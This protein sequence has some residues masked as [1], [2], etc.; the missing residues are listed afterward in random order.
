MDKQGIFR[1]EGNV[2]SMQDLRDSFDSG[3]YIDY[4]KFEDVNNVTSLLKFWLRSLPTP[5]LPNATSLLTLYDE[6]DPFSSITSLDLF[7]QIVQSSERS[8]IVLVKEKNNNN[9][10]N[11][12]NDNILDS[13]DDDDYDEEGLRKDREKIEKLKNFLEQI[14]RPIYRVCFTIFRLCNLSLSSPPP[15]PSLPPPLLSPYSSLT[16]FLLLLL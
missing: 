2:K 7:N 8:S 5:L 4:M 11:D 1:M 6:I 16:L 3:I 15:L 13:D 10:N 9:D 14:P 12:N